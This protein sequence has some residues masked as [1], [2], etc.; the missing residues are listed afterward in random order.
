MSIATE[1]TTATAASLTSE[2]ATATA[3]TSTSFA[4]TVTVSAV[5]ASGTASLDLVETVVSS[6]GEG[7]AGGLRGLGLCSGSVC[8]VGPRVD[9]LWLGWLVDSLSLGGVARD[10]FEGGIE[11]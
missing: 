10:D 8:V 11:V 9:G 7:G 2:A 1:S 3:A 6:A 4:V 5:S